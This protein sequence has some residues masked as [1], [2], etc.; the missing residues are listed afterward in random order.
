MKKKKVN[1]KI[2]KSEFKVKNN[3]NFNFPSLNTC[4]SS[5]SLKVFNQKKNINTLSGTTRNKKQSRYFPKSISSKRRNEKNKISK[6]TSKITQNFFQR[7]I[8]FIIKIKLFY[9]LFK[10]FVKCFINNF[11]F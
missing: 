8:C 6:S 11:F 7:W 4:G 2:S 10:Y 5:N 1:E 9:R 3:N